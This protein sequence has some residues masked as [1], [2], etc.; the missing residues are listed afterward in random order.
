MNYS[1]KDIEQKVREILEKHLGKNFE[2]RIND[3]TAWEID[4]IVLIEILVEIEYEFD[5]D[6]DDEQLE[7]TTIQSSDQL[8]E[9]VKNKIN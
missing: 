5:F 1:D 6:F 3:N 7:Y 8:I 2:D 9:C 4:S